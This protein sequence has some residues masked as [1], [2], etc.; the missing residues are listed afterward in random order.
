MAVKSGTI[1]EIDGH[2]KE[3]VCVVLPTTSSGGHKGTYE[4]LS[5]ISQV[6]KGLTLASPEFEIHVFLCLDKEDLVYD[7][8]DTNESSMIDRLQESLRDTRIIFRE[9]MYFNPPAPRPSVD[10]RPA[11]RI[12]EMWRK[13]TRKAYDEAFDN[14]VLLGDDVKISTKY[15]MSMSRAKYAAI[16][17]R[18][19]VP[20]G[21]GCVAFDDEN[22]RAF[23]TF[24]VMH[25]THMDIFNG[26]MIPEVFVNQDGDPYLY[27]VYRRWGASVIAR[28]CRLSN[29]V[30]GSNHPRLVLDCIHPAVTSSCSGSTLR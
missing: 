5:E 23:P 3:K 8:R 26:L 27:D 10:N 16:Q 4:C 2:Q 25:R 11:A 1:L 6:S 7:S 20:Y 18:L 15:W 13:A 29:G 28:E 12:C 22:F 21:F 17:R 24:P 9:P 19:G 14:N 30:G